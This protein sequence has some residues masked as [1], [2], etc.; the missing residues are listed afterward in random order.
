ML[1]TAYEEYQFAI[2]ENGAAVTAT[3]TAPTDGF[4]VMSGSA[5]IKGTTKDSVQC[6]IAVKRGLHTTWRGHHYVTVHDPGGSHT[7]NQQGVC[8]TD[9]VLEMPAGTFEVSLWFE[10]LTTAQAKNS[11]I[12]VIF[13]PFDGEGNP[14]VDPSF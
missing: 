3:I 5:H 10:S 7:S 2:T 11:V 12:W 1:R 13:V 14:P 6:S 4:L 9:A 8:A